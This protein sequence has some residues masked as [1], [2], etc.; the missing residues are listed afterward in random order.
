M[1]PVWVGILFGA[2]V[3]A[4]IVLMSW[5]RRVEPAELGTVSTQWLAEHRSNDGH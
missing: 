1:S 4:A 5:R 2:G 3:I